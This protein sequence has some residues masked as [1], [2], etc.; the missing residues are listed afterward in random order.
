ML[1]TTLRLL[2]QHGACYLDGE[3]DPAP[4]LAIIG[5]RGED[6]PIALSEAIGRLPLDDV[7][8][9]LRAVPAEQEA[10]RDRVARLYACDCAERVLPLWLARYPDDDRPA[11]AIAASRRYARGEATAKERAAAWAAAWAAARAAARAAAE[12][13]AEAA[14]W[15]AEREW[16]T[17]ALRR[18]LTSGG[19]Q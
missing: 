12:A 13:A 6:D 3:H 11:Q 9:A 8:W 1:T 14:A 19:G 2:R 7:L 15:A 4:L 18:A 17:E 5:D 10:E 16:Q